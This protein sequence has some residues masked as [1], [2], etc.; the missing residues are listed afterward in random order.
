MAISMT[1][2]P[3][4]AP[5][6]AHRCTPDNVELCI[7]PALEFESTILSTLPFAGLN[8]GELEA[9]NSRFNV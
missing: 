3:P 7:E 9:F 8:D 6:A 5:A 1:T 2:N 4:N